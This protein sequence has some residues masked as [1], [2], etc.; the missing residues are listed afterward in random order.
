MVLRHLVIHRVVNNL[1]TFT[2]TI[3]SLVHLPL[4]RNQEQFSHRSDGIHYISTFGVLGS[5]PSPV[6]IYY[7]DTDCVGIVYHSNYLKYFERGGSCWGQDELVELFD[8][9]AEV[10]SL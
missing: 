9:S 5:M 2:T 8:S 7:E 6:K 10:L 1:S 3:P 4:P